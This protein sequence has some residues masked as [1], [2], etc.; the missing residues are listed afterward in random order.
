MIA[1]SLLIDDHIHESNTLFPMYTDAAGDS[2][3]RKTTLDGSCFVRA[4]ELV[5]RA[6]MRLRACLDRNAALVEELAVCGSKS[7]KSFLMWDEE[8]VKIFNHKKENEALVVVRTQELSLATQA[9]DSTVMQ[10]TH[11]DCALGLAS[12]RSL[13]AVPYSAHLRGKRTLGVL[14]AHRN[15]GAFMR[16]GKY[17]VEYMSDAGR[18]G[19]LAIDF[20]RASECVLR[21]GQTLHLHL[22]F[23]L[24]AELTA[25]LPNLRLADPQLHAAL[26]EPGGVCV[27]EIFYVLGDSKKYPVQEFG[28]KSCIR[29][30][31]DKGDGIVIL[32]VSLFKVSEDREG[33]K[34]YKSI[35]TVRQFPLEHTMSYASSMQVVDKNK[36]HGAQARSSKRDSCFWK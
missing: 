1:G 7:K 17:Y 26:Q 5:K 35:V 33:A 6:Q 10:I 36:P 9:A 34:T 19:S 13:L 2:Y 20:M 21:E 14:K 28:T 23:E 24:Y 4:E 8:Y 25:T 15:T 11:E 31:I 27:L 30:A 29:V 18:Y 12:Q 22:D 16:M 32:F 3:Y